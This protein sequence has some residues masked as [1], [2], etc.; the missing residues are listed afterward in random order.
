[1]GSWANLAER[2]NALLNFTLQ[3]VALHRE[4]M[5]DDMERIMHRVSTLQV[6]IIESV[7]YLHQY[8]VLTSLLLTNY[9]LLS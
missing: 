3:N 6:N 2:L 4:K 5:T 8:R 1:M 9:E 7:L